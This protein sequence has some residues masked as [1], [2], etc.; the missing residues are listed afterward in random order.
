MIRVLLVEDHAS[1]RQALAFMLERESDITV[2]GQAGSL[3]E[4]RRLLA[5]VD[6][7]VLDLELPDGNGMVLIE[8]LR[9]ANPHG[10]VLI[11]T[12]SADQGDLARVIELGAAGTLNKSVGAGEI[13]TAIRRLSAGETLFSPGEIV[14][15]LR[16][17]GR[18]RE[19]TREAQ[20]ALDRLTRREH[21]VLQALAAGL[22]DKEIARRLHIS[23]ETVR[24][25]MVNLLAKLGVESRLQAVVF[26][27]RHGAVKFE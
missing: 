11:L 23:A 22:T 15:L 12:A 17:A 13:V 27:A 21:E 3:A 7:A 18:Q 5:G 20:L 4:A 19:R 2:V 1:F 10:R 25:H 14:E 9:A 8:E 16:L 24:T 26:A 6:V